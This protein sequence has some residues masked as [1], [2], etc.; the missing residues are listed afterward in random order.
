MQIIKSLLVTMILLTLFTLPIKA[1]STPEYE[2]TDNITITWNEASPKAQYTLMIYDADCAGC[3]IPD[4]VET[5]TS[6]E[7]VLDNAPDYI[8][9]LAIHIEAFGEDMD[10]ALIYP[11][12]FV[13]NPNYDP[14][15]PMPERDENNYRYEFDKQE[16]NL[17]DTAILED[18]WLNIDIREVFFSILFGA[19]MISIAVVTSIFLMK[20]TNLKFRF[21][22]KNTKRSE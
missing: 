21:T 1:L 3:M 4:L 11:V 19:F 16:P 15:A 8:E 18:N 7:I 12:V 14:N 9:R 10:E 22:T 20:G 5:T 2:I 13:E 17:P 6:T